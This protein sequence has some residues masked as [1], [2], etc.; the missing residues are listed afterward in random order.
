MTV[1]GRA[2]AGILPEFALRG[3]VHA[4]AAK[5]SRRRFSSV[6]PPLRIRGARVHQPSHGKS[7]KRALAGPSRASTV[8]WPVRQRRGWDGHARPIL[9]PH[10][11]L[12]RLTVYV[13]SACCCCCCCCLARFTVCEHPDCSC[14]ETRHGCPGG[15][16][17]G[18]R[19]RHILDRRRVHAGAE[20]CSQRE[21]LPRGPEPSDWPHI[22]SRGRCSGGSRMRRAS[23]SHPRRWR[24][25]HDVPQAR[26]NRRTRIPRTFRA[27]SGARERRESATAARPEGVTT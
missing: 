4:S 6:A 5:S 9:D 25:G 12:R 1:P 14:I 13:A 17:C 20:D 18:G 7:V 21:A 24:T 11:E 27:R 8:S 2:H 16:G 3:L 23:P 22:E 19:A 26:L 15:R 10:G